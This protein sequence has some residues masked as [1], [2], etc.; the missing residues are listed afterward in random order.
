MILCLLMRAILYPYIPYPNL[1]KPLLFVNVG[2][3]RTT[4][5]DICYK[6]VF[7]TAILTFHLHT[8]FIVPTLT[9]VVQFS[10][11]HFVIFLFVI[12]L[13]YFAYSSFSSV[14]HV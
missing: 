1:I 11:M 2:N 4:I 6:S 9:R 3:Y 10:E 7:E 5:H 8:M 12:F 14:P 13:F